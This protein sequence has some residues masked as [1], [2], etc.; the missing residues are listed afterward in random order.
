MEKLKEMLFALC[1][2][3]GAPGAETEAAVC[4]KSY[5]EPV[6]RVEID[7]MGNVIARLGKLGAPKRI[8][9]NAHMDQVSMMVTQVD[10]DGFVHIA[11]CGGVD[12]RVLPGTPVTVLGREPLV[13]IVC[14]EFRGAE[15]IPPLEEMRVDIGLSR[16]EAEK[17]VAPGDRIVYSGAPQS[18]L[19][20][21]VTSPSLDD[22]AGCAAVIRAA[23]LLSQEDLAWEA[24]VLLSSQE[25]TGGPGAGC[26]AYAVDPMQAICVDVSFAFQP[27][28]EKGRYAK[29]GGGPMIGVAPVLS[30]EM[31][32]AFKRLAKEESIPYQIEAMGGATGTDI[33]HICAVRSGVACGMLSLPQRNMHTPAEMVDLRDLEW[34]ARL[35]A[36]YV[37]GLC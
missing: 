32:A 8:L 11:P 19:G 26:A 4:A 34:T 20:S 37:R 6:S 18:L 9:L 23:Q 21:L 14:G 1:R 2:A 30:Q 16:E 7:A 35:I 22:R 13:G 12:R 33:D 17:L 25:E 28:L 10:E 29:L 31:I 24:I 36:A 15:K 27:G 3:Q 5:L